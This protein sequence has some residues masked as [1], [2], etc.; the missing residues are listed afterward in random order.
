MGSPAESAHVGKWTPPVPQKHEAEAR[1][2]IR[3]GLDDLA[4]PPAERTRRLFVAYPYDF[5]KADYRRPFTELAKAFDVE[6]QFADERITNKH[7]LD[8]VTDMIV[9]AR[10]SLF[11]VT[12]WNANVALE[13]GIA[14][15]RGRD[16]YLLFNPTHAD[17][18]KAD[19]PAD[20]GGLDRIQY[21]SNT[22]SRKG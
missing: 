1:L 18:P 7:L 5:P 6:F 9:T 4:R 16:F 20:L 13:L 10:F 22:E 21:T 8:K 3:G 15:G 14:S 12:T 17:N 11:D 19:V 2:R